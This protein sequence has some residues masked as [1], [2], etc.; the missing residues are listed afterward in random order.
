MMVS[1]KSICFSFKN[2]VFRIQTHPKDLKVRRKRKFNLLTR[3]PLL[4]FILALQKE[5]QAMLAKTEALSHKTEKPRD[6][7]THIE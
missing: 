3:I 2:K 7:L 4:V 1:R 5:E 6:R